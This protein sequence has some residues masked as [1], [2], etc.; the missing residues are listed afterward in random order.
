MAWFDDAFPA[1]AAGAERISAN[2][3]LF[4]AAGG[5]GTPLVVWRTGTG[6]ARHEGAP[7]DIDAWLAEMGR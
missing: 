7:A 1:T 2:N 5:T 3:A 4:D 6:V